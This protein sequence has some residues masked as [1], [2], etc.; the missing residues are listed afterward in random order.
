MSEAVRLEASCIFVETHTSHI[1]KQ[2]TILTL[3]CTWRGD[4]WQ[5]TCALPRG[6]KYS[7]KIKT[8]HIEKFKLAI[9]KKYC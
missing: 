2:V 3:R 5:Q 7:D 4:T 6:H 9:A 8:T 1:S